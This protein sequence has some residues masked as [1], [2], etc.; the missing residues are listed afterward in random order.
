MHVS[1]FLMMRNNHLVTLDAFVVGRGGYGTTPRRHGGVLTKK[2]Q[3]ANPAQR[4]ASWIQ[5]SI[6]LVDICWNGSTLFVERLLCL[7]MIIENSHSQHLKECLSQRLLVRFAGQVT[8]CAPRTEDNTSTRV[9]PSNFS[10]S[11][12]SSLCSFG[13]T[14]SS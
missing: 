3:Q 13:S 9:A 12:S 11:F 2:V 7:M 4:R 1:L 14:S 5:S 6:S 10:S 8:A